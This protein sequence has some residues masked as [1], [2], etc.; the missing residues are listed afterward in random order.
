MNRF[1]Q[2]PSGLRVNTAHILEYRE[3]SLGKLSI[4]QSAYQGLDGRFPQIHE[5]MTAE[6]LDAL[7]NG[8]PIVDPVINLDKLKRGS[9]CCF[10][11]DGKVRHGTIEF[12]KCE[13][14]IGVMSHGQDFSISLQ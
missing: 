6:Q 10:T 12:L 11:R 2:L 4:V 1:I 8:S 9:A 7:V 5:D 3:L 13:G 14:F